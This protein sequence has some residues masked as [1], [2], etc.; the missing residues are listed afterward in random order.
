MSLAKGRPMRIHSEDCDL[1]VPVLGDILD[2]LDSIDRHA[3]I[4]FVPLES[5]ALAELW[6]RLVRISD[7]L[8]G[9][10]RVHYR[11]K[12]PGLEVTEIDSFSNDLQS[13]AQSMTIPNNWNDSLGVHARQIELFYQLVSLTQ[14]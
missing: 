5:Q 10:M 14:L 11:L 7:I 6:I 9:I 2:E 12:G 3:R 4:K 1:P 8:G 13:L